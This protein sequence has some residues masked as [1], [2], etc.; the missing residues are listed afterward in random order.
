MKKAALVA[1]LLAF[2]VSL[3]WHAPVQWWL[4][5]LAIDG[6]HLQPQ[7]GTL[8]QG[9]ALLVRGPTQVPLTWQLEASTLWHGML[10][11]RVRVLTGVDQVLDGTL[12]WAAW[13]PLQLQSKWQGG[14]DLHTI[15]RLMQPSLA[16]WLQGNLQVQHLS[17]VMEADEDWPDR[18]A[19][20]GQITQLRLLHTPWPTL[21]WT[22]HQAD[23]DSL[24]AEA[25]GQAPWGQIQF[26]L[27]VERS[28]RARLTGT[29]VPKPGAA[30]PAGLKSLFDHNTWRWQGRWR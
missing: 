3:A 23:A 25:K 28:G 6:V 14:V 18:I 1:F 26:M 8:A 19:G 11:G 13:R 17:V 2:L 12:A 9:Q 4:P 20:Q 21:N 24:V 27:Q 16:A 15:A 7:T 5:P 29:L 30:V 10:A 22:L